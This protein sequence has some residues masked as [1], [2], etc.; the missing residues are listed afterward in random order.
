VIADEAYLTKSMM[1]P[2]ADIVSG[3]Q[4]VMPTYAGTLEAA[5]VAALVEYIE[6]L[7]EPQ[8]PGVNLPRVRAVEPTEDAAPPAATDLPSTDGGAR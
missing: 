2:N 4:P 6:S 5:E 8:E 7:R 3:F 1:D